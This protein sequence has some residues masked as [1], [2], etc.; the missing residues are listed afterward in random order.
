MDLA[1]FRELYAVEMQ[2]Q[3]DRLSRALLALESDPAHVAEAFR[4]AH[5]I[6]GLAAAMRHH[7]ITAL[8]HRLEDGLDA[9]RGGEEATDAAIDAL[10]ALADELA[11]AAASP[12][13]ESSPED[14]VEAAAGADAAD[15]GAGDRAPIALRAPAPPPGATAIG[16]VLRADAAIK[17]ARALLV[18]RAAA[19]AANVVGS[20]PA[21][22]DES[23][24]GEFFIFVEPPVER[25]SLEQA[26]RGAGDVEHVLFGDD[27][28]TVPDARAGEPA[29]PR[30]AAPHVRVEQRRLDELS[31][32][33]AEL[34]VQQARLAHLAGE[35]DA[36]LSPLLEA[37]GRLVAELQV[38]ILSLRMLPVAEVFDR[39]PRQARD[40]ARQL[41]K[42]VDVRIE[43]REIR[44]DRAILEEIAEPLLHLL[45]NAIGHGLEP[46]TDRL[47]RAKPRR[48]SVLIQ[49]ERARNSVRIVLSDDGRGIDRAR[50]AA[51]ARAVGL[52]AAAADGPLGDEDMLRLLGQPGF[53][54]MD[55]VTD[56]SGRGVGLDAVVT[57]VRALGG[58]LEMQSEPGHGTRFTLHLPITLALAQALRVR[59]GDE[60]YAIPLTHVTEAIDFAD[61]P[62]SRHGDREFVRVRSDAVPLVRLRRVLGATADGTEAAAVLAEIG[63][64]RIAL[65]VDVL[66]GR[67]QIL[68]KPFDAAT[69]TLPIF[70]GVTILADGRPALVL[71]PVSVA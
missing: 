27:A 37:M 67:E 64:R 36:T 14:D 3:I 62:P 7:A 57:R 4:A 23:F 21:A 61:A 46:P 20:D 68:V 60:E 31:D 16:V 38:E 28:A 69:G 52:L 10:L 33:V 25:E 45:R 71:D 42:E 15:A 5:T 6:K 50:V 55:E 9:L 13:A 2:E 1:R 39:L 34:S 22:F 54:T 59:V 56:V 30:L 65:A 44:L 17:S 12:P 49:A 32:A 63:E 24:T 51:R 8:A 19:R 66:L 35:G 26:I 40:L 48:G 47:A 43:G 29:A 18:M 70:S 58:A 11:D 41:G 53:S